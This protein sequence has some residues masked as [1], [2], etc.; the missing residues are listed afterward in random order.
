MRGPQSS[1][2]QKP[3]QI[4]SPERSAEPDAKEGE[5]PA[6]EVGR[7]SREGQGYLRGALGGLDP[8]NFTLSNEDVAGTKSGLTCA[9][10]GSHRGRG[11]RD[12]VGMG[13]MVPVSVIAVP[14]RDH[15][16][17]GQEKQ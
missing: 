13:K 8:L 3:L 5:A 9:T 11:C 4:E 12:Q 17:L 2:S 7:R 16:G 6:G 1:L 14:K 10:G 15:G